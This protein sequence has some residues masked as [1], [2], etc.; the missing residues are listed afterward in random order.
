MNLSQ[1]L[2]PD[3]RGA[4]AVE[5][6]LVLPVFMLLLMGGLEITHTKYVQTVLV[7]QLQK[8]GRDMSLE[9]SATSTA[10]SSVE[11]S[12]TRSIQAVAPNARVSYTLQSF[13]DYANVASRPEPY[14]DNDSDGVCDH[15][16]TFTDSNGNGHWDV[17]GAADGRG[18]A[19]DVVLLTATVTYP[20]I[21]LGWTYGSG[22]TVT[23][24]ASTLLRN[25]PSSTQSLP[26]TGICP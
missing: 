15:G 1:T 18:G 20:R 10:Q 2:W 24:Q 3:R 22:S 7:G 23:L 16:E 11:A 9:G 25:Q 19:N 17:D 6:A 13:H 21:A 8:A 14:V 26:A 5:F 4:A 12:V